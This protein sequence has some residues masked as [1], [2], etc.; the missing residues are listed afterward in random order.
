MKISKLLTSPI[1]ALL[2]SLLVL[3]ACVPDPP[4]KQSD[5]CQ[6]FR[7]YPD[8]YWATQDTQK[9]WHVPISVQMAIIHQESHF[10][11]NAKPPRTKLL[12]VIPWTRPTS[13]YGYSQAVDGTWAIYEKE[14]DSTRFRNSF[15]SASDFLGWYAARAHKRAGIS[16]TNAYQLYL[17]YHE[18]IGG[19]MRGSHAKKAWLIA[20]AKKVE[21]QASMYHYQLIKCQKNLPKKPWWQIW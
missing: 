4:K 3:T 2:I 20:V 11:G 7:E 1:F 6:I 17:A 18:G 21:R 16:R 10:K 13:A 12:W 5:V 8:W 14:T 19:Y 15:S 9:K